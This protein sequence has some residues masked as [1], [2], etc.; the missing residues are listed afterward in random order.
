MTSSRPLLGELGLVGVVARREITQRARRPAFRI[1]TVLLALL[2]VAAVVLPEWLG[3]GT[4]HQDV[5]VVHDD[6]SATVVAATEAAARANELD[7]DVRELPDRGAAVAAV[8]AGDADVAVVAGAGRAELVWQDVED[9]TL[10][11]VVVAGLTQAALID[12]AGALGLDRDGLETLLAPVKPSVSVLE[13]DRSRTADGIIALAGMALLF[14]AISIYGSYVLMGVVEEKASRVVEVLLARISPAQLLAGKVLGVGLLGL[15]Q[16]LV[17]GTATAASLAV[18]DPPDWPDTTTGAIATI[19]VWF[20]L[21]YGF[22]SMLYGALGS[23]A[24][25]AEDAQAAVAPL[26]VG[27]LLVYVGAFAALSSPGAWWVTLGSLLP[28]TAPLF[29]PVRVALVDVPAWQVGLAVVLMLAATVGLARVGGQL[30]R[31]AV[32]RLGSRVRLREAWAG[33][34]GDRY[35]D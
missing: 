25:R 12:R 14:V 5:V 3:G 28:P 13:V 10:S 1:A 35:R 18:V 8:R 15:A 20:V 24:S 33:R 27:L 21:G 6:R 23:L 19:I 7:V 34:A 29:L 30:Y 11:R 32:L 9:P 26:T 16:L 22:Y 4:E 2:G 31:G 17:V